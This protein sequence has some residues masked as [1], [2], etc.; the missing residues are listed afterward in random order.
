MA[1]PQTEKTRRKATGSIIA[2]VALF[3]MLALTTYAL[4]FSLVSVEDNLFETAKVDIELNGGKPVFDGSDLHV[5][6]G[7]ALVQDFTAENRSTVD[8]HVR[9]YLE[10]V[11]GTLQEALTFAIYDGETQL[12]SGTAAELTRENPCMSGE[13]LAAGET[14]TLTAVVTMQEEAGNAYQ[15]GGIIFDMTADAVQARNNPDKAFA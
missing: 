12:F 15:N 7:H 8:V 5:E 11:E 4:V 1:N 6:P 3:C 9:L 13:P 14:R 2:I 10:N